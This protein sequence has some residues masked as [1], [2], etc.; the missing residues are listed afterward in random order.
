M[1]MNVGNERGENMEYKLLLDL[2]KM[3]FKYEYDI[4]LKDALSQLCMNHE[5]NLSIYIITPHPENKHKWIFR[6]DFLEQFD[7]WGNAYYEW[8]VFDL[9][10]DNITALVKDM[11]MLISKKAKILN[12]TFD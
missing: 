11:K 2:M 5:S 7:K 9:N 1:A 8:A 10:L 4:E 6:A 12:E 3:G